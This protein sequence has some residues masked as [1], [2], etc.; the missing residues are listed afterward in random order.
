MSDKVSAP[1]R[2]KPRLKWLRVESLRRLRD[3]FQETAPT[4]QERAQRLW[5]V[6]R[7][8]IL[9]VKAAFLLVLFYYFYLQPWYEL[10][11]DLVAVPRAVALQAFRQFFLIYAAVSLLVAGVL[12]NAR[13][14]GGRVVSWVI[15]SAN[16]LD[17]L[18][19]AALLYITGGFD[20]LVYWLFPGLI[21]RNALSSPRARPQLILNGSVTLCYLLA[22]LLDVAYPDQMLDFG[23]F[24]KV[25]ATS[26]FSLWH[27]FENAS[28]VP[29]LEME[30]LSGA[31]PEGSVQPIVIRVVVLLLWTTWC[32][33]VQV[34]LEKQRRTLEAAAE[35]AARQEQLRA[36]GRLAAEIAHGIKNPLGIINAT[37]YSLQQASQQKRAIKADQ[38]A[39]IRDEVARA[40]AIITRLMGYAQLAEGR[41]EQLNIAEELDKALREV[42]PPGA[43]YAT[44][45]EKHVAP[46]LPSLPMQRL[47]LSQIL[48]NVLL[49]AREALEGNGELVIT[50]GLE[51]NDTITV[52]IADNGPGIPPERIERIFEP[53]VTFKET[54]NGHGTGHRTSQYR[55]L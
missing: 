41:V 2:A 37:A 20:S 12:W 47:H 38:L 51:P 50:A 7:D 34:L 10:G 16:F 49:N 44:R 21:V 48:E 5:T 53:Y 36:A 18:F 1:S 3:L 23:D 54:G 33:G 26:G 27:F 31:G 9:P 8:V 19:L 25:G 30:V 13:R 43:G 40:D 39:M 4:P 52:T 6:E 11:G 55:D 28:R 46:D 35:S 32:Y 14:V 15:F 45:I 24:N 42:F 29:S 17:G 22:G